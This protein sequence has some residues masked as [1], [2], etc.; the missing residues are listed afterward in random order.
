MSVLR[1]FALLLSIVIPAQIWAGEF[2]AL[3]A[4]VDRRVSWLSEHVT[5]EK[6]DSVTSKDAFELSSRE[7]HV[8]IRATGANAA[9]VGL[10]WYLKYYCHRSMSHMG[11]NLSPVSPL[12]TIEKPETVVSPATYRYALNYCT[13]NY[14]MSF[15]NWEDWQHELD[16]M[17]LN[18]VNLMLA[19]NGMEVVWQNVLQELG[20]NRQEI[21]DFLVGPAYTAWWLM[22][23]IQ[24]WGG[25]MPAS[26]LDARKQLQQKIIT[27][28]KELG[29]EPV[30]PG[31]YGM[32][33]SSLKEK[34]KARII[35]QG[36]W[37]AFTRPDILDPNDPAFTR[38]AGLYYRTI[39]EFY[40]KDLRF[41]SGDPFHE[42]GITEGV[43]LAAAG[44]AIQREMNT[45][46]PDSTWVLQGW[47]N[48]PKKEM[49]DGLDKSKVLVQELFG[50]FTNN[51]E[52]RA[53]YESTPFIWCIVNNFGERPG[54]FGKLQR[55]ADEVVRA[56][57][58]PYGAY[59]RGVGIMPEGIKN[60][61][62]A[63]DLTL[64]LGWRKDH[65]DIAKW[66]SDF[67][68]YRYGDS[69]KD[70]TAAWGLLLETVYNSIPGYQEGAPESVFCRR[71]TLETKPVSSW[72][73]RK[74]NYD[75]AKF[76]Q[77]VKRFMQA[78]PV[79]KDSQTYRIDLIN[80]ARQ[81]LANKGEIVF[82]EMVDAAGKK[83]IPVFDAA[84]KRFLDLIDL[85]DDLLNTDPYYCLSTWQE[86]ALRL[87][88]TPQEK[89]L[90]LHNAMMLI[91][92]WGENDPAE[93]NL[94][95]YAY[96]EWAGMMKAFYKKRWEFY[97]DHLRKQWA[98]ESTEPLDFFHWERQWVEKNREIIKSSPSKELVPIVQEILAL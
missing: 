67:A 22:G 48:N 52:T 2:D 58:S 92:Y 41:F 26:M 59:L 87:G 18:G 83:D 75:T 35:E 93:D 11:D 60:N 23:N 51:W 36:K 21:D 45:Y 66:I 12:P 65:V 3:D 15:Y 25:P 64:E 29:I 53:G 32:V 74:R 30:I 94:H 4:L 17:A 98:G 16:W 86:Q 81:V 61:P 13:Y 90:C 27:R 55:Y 31:F 70:I 9:A 97:F 10:N 50:E 54:L 78:A 63:Y 82:Q 88:Q 47:Q 40:G 68:A 33:P 42:G 85:T 96:K 49:L 43:D 20:Y 1:K 84:T 95:E 37:G 71:P 91:T 80:F 79:L 62:V 38:I 69:N 39:Q 24:K 46:F 5:F 89:D 73:T 6:L 76:E 19:A 8:A 56:R 57:K 7:N 14:T 77:A 44:A 72:G 28:M 34:I